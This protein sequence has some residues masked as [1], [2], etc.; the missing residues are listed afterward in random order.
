M[1]FSALIFPNPLVPLLPSAFSLLKSSS[2]FYFQAKL[3]GRDF[4]TD[5]TLPVDKQVIP[6]SL[7]FLPFVLPFVWLRDRFFAHL[8][9]S[10]FELLH[11]GGPAHST[12]HVA[13][14]FV[15]MLHWMVCFLVE[16]CSTCK[17]LYSGMDPKLQI[18][19][20]LP[21]RK[22]VRVILVPVKNCAKLN[23]VIKYTGR[24]PI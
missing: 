5:E 15:P 1:I 14:K 7:S 6:C 20:L 24:K 18:V 10:H 3:N 19:L 17:S 8:A 12:G 21:T 9:V 11:K 22:L 4:N 2:F 16:M 23:A 13:R